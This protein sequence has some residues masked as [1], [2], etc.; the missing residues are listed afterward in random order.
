MGSYGSLPLLF[1]SKEI[2]FIRPVRSLEKLINIF[3]ENI[4]ESNSVCLDYFPEKIY[5]NF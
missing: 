5:L 3:I 4:Y 1:P 2:E